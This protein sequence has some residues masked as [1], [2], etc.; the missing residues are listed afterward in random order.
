MEHLEQLRS[1][2]EAGQRELGFSH[3][4][5]TES[6]EVRHVLKKAAATAGTLS[7]RALQLPPAQKQFRA[8]EVVQH[9][10]GQL[11]PMSATI[12]RKSRVA[13]AGAAIVVVEESPEAVPVGGTGDIA[14]VNRPRRW[15]LVEA[16]QLLPVTDGDD[17]PEVAPPVSRSDVEFAGPSYATSFKL[18]RRDISE[19]GM[20]VLLVE[21][22]EAIGLGL[23]RAADHCLLTA[24]AAATPPAFSLASAAAAGVE[25]AELKALCGTAAAGAAVGDDGTLRV[26]GVLAELTPVNAAT[27]V[28]AFT[29]SAVAVHDS[30]RVSVERRNAAGDLVVTIWSDLV[31][32]LPSGDA[33][34]W[35]VSA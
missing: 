27:V 34:F 26:S 30:L 21:L 19:H 13:Q 31:A 8:L 9:P 6:G 23:A 24:I 7:L 12:L 4:G 11:V 18:N 32:L 16:A 3:H 33:K 17:V 35:T 15:S 28:G 25:F 2:I 5:L 14:L 1:I 20:D 29:R 22:M 10:A